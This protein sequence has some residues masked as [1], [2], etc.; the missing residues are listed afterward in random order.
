MSDQNPFYSDIGGSLVRVL[1]TISAV[2]DIRLNAP[3]TCMFFLV[4]EKLSCW[5]DINVNDTIG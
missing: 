1:R 5:K 4:G 3:C 2:P